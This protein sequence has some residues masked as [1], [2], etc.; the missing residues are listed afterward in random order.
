M[1]RLRSVIERI[2]PISQEMVKEAQNRL[3]CLTKPKGSLGRLEEL[4]KKV[5]GITRNLTPTFNNKVII[6]M[7]ADHGV[8]EEGISAYPQEVTAQMVYNFV[9]GGVDMGVKEKLKV[10]S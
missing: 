2:E 3:D 1:D 4:A 6:I 5:V 9:R 8:V 7:A 10:K